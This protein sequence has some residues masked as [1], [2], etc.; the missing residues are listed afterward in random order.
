MSEEYVWLITGANRGIGLEIVKQL[1]QSPSNIIIAAC[2]NPAKA[3]ELQELAKKAG[4]KVHVIELDVSDK[5]SINKA[6][7]EVSGVLG[8]KGIDYLVNNAGIAL[9]GHDTAF[10]M[11]LDVMQKTFATNVVGPAYVAQAFIGLV[12]KSEKKTIV[13]IS[14][15]IGSIA[16]DFGGSAASYAISKTAL[17]MLTYKQAKEMPQI[18]VISMCPG[19]LQTDLGGSNATHPVSV[20][21][22]GV[23]KTISSLKPEDS[24]QFLNFRGERVPW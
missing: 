17:N 2:R 3:T 16:S 24:G 13:N 11:D 1:L 18:T 8:G 23:L 21:V 12:E 4:G 20:G 10:S 5:E 9:G 22:A 6:A 7:K 15:T 19:W 14:S